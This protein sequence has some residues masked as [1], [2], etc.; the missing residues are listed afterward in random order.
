MR[1]F[2]LELTFAAAGA[3]GED[4]EDKLGAI[5]DFEVENPFEVAKLGRREVVVE[6]DRA[7]A[8]GS[9]AGVDLL[10]FASPYQGSRIGLRGSLQ[11]RAHH[12]GSSAGGEFLELAKRLFRVGDNL[13][14]PDA[15]RGSPPNQICLFEAC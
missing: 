15:T 2:Y 10:H 1:Q 5:E 14:Q 4:V 6:D 12:E 3:S 7:R 13:P 11:D 9:R 8:A